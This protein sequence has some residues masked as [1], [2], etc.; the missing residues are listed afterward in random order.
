[1]ADFQVHIAQA[2]HNENLAKYLL[3]SEYFDWSITG[4]FYSAIHFFEAS[5]FLRSKERHSEIS[6]PVDPDGKN[7][8]SP[9]TWRS[10]LIQR[11]YS[12]DVWRCFRSLKE[13]SETARYLSNSSGPVVF[14]TTPSYSVLS[15]DNATFALET[16]LATIKA[17]LNIDFFKFIIDLDFEGECGV[18]ASLLIDKIVMNIVSKEEFLRET[19]TSLRVKKFSK[20]EIDFIES[21]L[22]KKGILLN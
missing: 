2:E 15:R 13:A 8:C 18:G 16:E 9:H 3:P 1:M 10:R 5:L 7:E 11:K 4:C 17:G 20:N 22:K 6:I 19:K 21:A 14:R 12:K